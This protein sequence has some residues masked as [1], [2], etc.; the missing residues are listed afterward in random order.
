MA[1]GPRVSRARSPSEP[2]G[3]RFALMSV[4]S[5]SGQANCNLPECFAGWMSRTDL[6]SGERR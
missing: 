2:R 4:N 6:N 3:V 5:Y 1:P